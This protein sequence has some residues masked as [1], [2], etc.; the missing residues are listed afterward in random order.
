MVNWKGPKLKRHSPVR[1][2]EAYEKLFKIA[3]APE[4]TG[5]E[6]LLYMKQDC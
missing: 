5:S 2:E 6:S 4:I 1:I 3:V